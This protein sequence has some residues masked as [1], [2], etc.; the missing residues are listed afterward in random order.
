M[1]GHRE[2][3][4]DVAQETLLK[5]FQ[6]FQ[7]LR[8]P[9]QVRPWVF[10]IAKN[11][12]LMKRRKSVFAPRELSLEEFYPVVSENGHRHLEMAGPGLLP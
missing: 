8:D 9:S 6:R 12:C 5:I 11:A 10:Q 3:A 4:E 2:D 7:Q 1:C